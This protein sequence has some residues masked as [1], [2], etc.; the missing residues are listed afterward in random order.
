VASIRGSAATE[1]KRH[2]DIVASQDFESLGSFVCGEGST[3]K[4]T[5]LFLPQ[6]NCSCTFQGYAYLDAIT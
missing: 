5:P 1:T 2:V 3:V 4:S 6:T